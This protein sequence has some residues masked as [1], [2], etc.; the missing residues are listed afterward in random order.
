MADMDITLWVREELNRQ[1]DEKYKKFHISL[2]PGL[3]TMI[4]VRVPIM[5][6]IAKKAAKQDYQGFAKDADIRVY[7]ERMVRGMMIGYAKLSEEERAQELKKFVPLIDNWAV[8]DCC[9]TTYKF[10]KK[11]QEE[12]FS[13][14]EQY[15][16]SGREYEIRFAVV[17][18]LDF[19][20][21]ESYINRILELF[22]QIHHDGYYVKMA[23]A[24][25]V[26]VCYV[27]FPRETEE[28]LLQDALDS[29]T[30]NKAI[31]K[32]RESYRVS[33]ED[34]DRLNEMKR[35]ETKS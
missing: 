9:C 7:E 29:F 21:N 28:F 16:R 27:K 12:W 17:C 4:G 15:A 35:K 31:Q 10:M 3:Q 5:R 32:I 24:W 18:M 14:L 1:A 30:H 2:V 26:S 23:V 34:K 6:E 13:F 22:S 25:A 33:K 20:V 8:C 19:F 11:N